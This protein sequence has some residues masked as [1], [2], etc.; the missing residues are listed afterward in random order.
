MM[1]AEHQKPSEGSES[2]LRQ[3]GGAI[4]RLFEGTVDG[5][6]LYLFRILYGFVLAFWAWDYLTSGRVTAIYVEPNYHFSYR[7]FEWIKPL[8]GFW[9]YGLFHL[10]LIASLGIAL[11]VFYR[12]SALVFAITRTTIICWRGS[13]GGCLGC[14]WIEVGV[15]VLSRRA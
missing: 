15:Y 9:M 7:G 13:R 10:L 2:L 3:V 11:G 5:C 1:A 6:G 4:R 8:P 14:R 12:I